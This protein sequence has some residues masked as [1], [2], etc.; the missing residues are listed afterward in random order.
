MQW[1]SW[2]L[3]SSETTA[4]SISF[5]FC[6]CQEFRLQT[7]FLSSSLSYNPALAPSA[8]WLP[9]RWSAGPWSPPPLECP[10]LAPVPVHRLPLQPPH[11]APILPGGGGKW[12]GECQVPPPGCSCEWW[13]QIIPSV[14]PRTPQNCCL[15]KTILSVAHAHALYT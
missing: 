7:T 10:H 13:A 9:G 6:C 3:H 14:L 8:Q 4:D 1:E 2:L 15:I 11:P 5:S 12:V